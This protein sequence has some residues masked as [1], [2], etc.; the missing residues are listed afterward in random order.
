MFIPVSV[1]SEVSCR[2]RE[3]LHKSVVHVDSVPAAAPSYD[4]EVL[5]GIPSTP[6]V[7]DSES[8]VLPPISSA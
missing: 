1:Q 6:S 5:V 8:I 4:R 7:V 3:V 2:H